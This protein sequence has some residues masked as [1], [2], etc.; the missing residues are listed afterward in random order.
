MAVTMREIAK[1]A[2]VSHTTA[3]L[4]LGGGPA[5]KRFS[6]DTTKLVREV[7]D[8]LGYRP[9]RTANIL[10]YQ[11]N[12]LIGVLSG[13]YRM[14][15]FGELLEGASKVVEPRFGVVPAVHHYNGENER[16]SLQMFLDMRLS[17]IIAFWSGDEKSIPLYRGVA[18]KYKIP[19]V[20]CDSPIPSIDAP[21][22]A[23][24][25]EEMA[26]LA[27][28]TLLENGHRKILGAL[29]HR[30]R[31]GKSLESIESIKGYHKAMAE[32]NLAEI[33]Y[34]VEPLEDNP[35]YSKEYTASVA[36]Y[37]DRI[38]EHL[39]DNNFKYT[40]IWTE[41]D[42]IAYELLFKLGKL[43]LKV[44]GDI[45]LIGMSNRESSRLS[46]ISMSSVASSSFV[47]NGK[48]LSKTLLG[49]IDGKAPESLK[50][51]RKLKVFLRNSIRKI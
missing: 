22:M 50:L 32:H 36:K 13:G 38:I 25:R 39:K 43:G 14:E 42:L 27:A 34:I 48:I 11:K 23:V 15:F 8:N 2:D 17:G 6:P 12:C 35:I 7:A 1:K 5:S 29:S 26:Y 44:P 19:M 31:S 18:E 9:N 41:D 40:A 10:R 16:H 3:S 21:C 33:D 24:N 28:S 20:L 37:A 49:M 4:I 46:S 47:E 51:E 45:S 30:E